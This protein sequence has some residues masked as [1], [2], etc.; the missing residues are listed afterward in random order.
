MALLESLLDDAAAAGRHPAGLNNRRIAG[1]LLQAIMFNAFAS[2][3]SGS[4]VRSDPARAPRSCGA[5][6]SAASRPLIR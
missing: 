6:C 4:S 3:I 2:T 1:V 5:S